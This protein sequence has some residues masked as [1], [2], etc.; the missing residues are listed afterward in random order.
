MRYPY[1]TL[2]DTF[3][4][5]A[6]ITADPSKANDAACGMFCS[7]YAG[8]ATVPGSASQRELDL[9]PIAAIA[10]AVRDEIADPKMQKAADKFREQLEGELSIR[11]YP[12]L[13]A[14]PVEVLD[15][16]R[17]WHYL[18]VR[19]FSEF[20]VWREKSALEKGNI[21][22]YF[23]SRGAVDSIPLRLY[24]RAQSVND[25]ADGVQLAAAIPEGTDFWRSHVIRVRTSRAVPLVT[26]FAE[27]QRDSRLTTAPLRQLARL[28]NRMW[29]NVVLLEYG[30]KDGRRLLDDLRGR[31]DLDE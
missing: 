21:A 13:Q 20:I 2:K 23:A 18:A 6:E 15:D 26:A 10:Q 17:F 3:A 7:E 28:V 8:W 31:L 9:G 24:L 12:A 1:L 16:Q 27:M 14:L 25:G 19:Y 5:A 30:K 29:A 22:K 11:L 4:V